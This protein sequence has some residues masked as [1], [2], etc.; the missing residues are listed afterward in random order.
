LGLETKTLIKQLLEAGVHFGH[1]KSKWN[2]KMREFIFADKSGIYIIDLQKTVEGLLKA[3]NFLFEIARKGENILFVGTK[4]QAQDTIK[5]V[6]E[7]S[8]MFYVS[9]RWLGGLLTNFGT[10]RKSV[11]RYDKIESMK[12]DGTFDKL[13]KKEASQLNKELLKLKKNLD[14]V[15]EMKKLPAALFIID[16]GKEDIAVKEAMK[17]HIPIVAL[18]DTNC[19]PDLVDYIIPG[20]DDALRSI[21]LI[22]SIVSDFVARGKNEFASGK[23]IEKADKAKIKKETVEEDAAVGAKTDELVEDAEAIEK[24]FRRGKKEEKLEQEKTIKQKQ[25]RQTPRRRE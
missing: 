10:V 18:I 11:A 20:N 9:N 23:E 14:G 15:R 22:A 4:K 5:E 12:Q 8:G 1:Q 7:K 19:N 25:P 13:S 21:K 6:A 24:R 2:P 17:L 3:C 16:P